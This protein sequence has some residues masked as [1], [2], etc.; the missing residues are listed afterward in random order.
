M[1][2]LARSV[3]SASVLAAAV[4]CTL[5]A[6]APQANAVGPH[7]DMVNRMD[8]S[9]LALYGDNTG[10]NALAITLRDPAYNYKSEQWESDFT[11][12]GQGNW[13][14]TVKNEAANKCLQPADSNPQRKGTVVVKSCNGSD[15]QKWLA[16][17][18]THG[19]TQW[20]QYR[21]KNNE[22]LAMTLNRYQGSGAWDTLHLDTAYKYPSS[23]RLWKFE[24]NS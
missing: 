1:S 3:R 6:T 19:G 22:R 2:T 24:P 7:K 21:P 4:T 14:G 8:G 10:E 16:T 13:Y 18:D 9:R 12:D 11:R 20:W 23:D 5:L 17:P 15:D